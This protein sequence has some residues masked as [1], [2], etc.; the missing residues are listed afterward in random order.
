VLVA[1][2][3]AKTPERLQEITGIMKGAMEEFPQVSP[4]QWEY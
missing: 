3:E 4:F 1:R 2:C